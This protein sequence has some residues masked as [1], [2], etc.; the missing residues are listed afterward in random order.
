MPLLGL[1]LLVLLLF[2][3]A[4]FRGRIF[5]YRD[6]HLV[7]HAQVE[8]FVRMV[9]EGA[10]PVWDRYVS[11][12]QPHWANPETQVLYPFTWLQAV[13]PAGAFY[14]AFVVFHCLFTAFGQ[15]ALARSWGLER[16]PA[17][18]AAAAWTA[19]GPFL[20]LVSLWHHFTGA[21]WI[22][23]VFLA[24]DRALRAPSPRRLALAGLAA[25]AQ[26]LAG[27]ADMAAM[28]L[29]G[30]ALLAVDH[31]RRHGQA[32]RR[33]LQAGARWGAA[34]AVAAAVSAAQ[35]M[36][37][38][39]LARRSGRWGLPDAARVFWSLPLPLAAQAVVPAFLDGLPLRPEVRAVLHESREPFLSSVY[40]GAVCALLVAGAL[41]RGRHS[42]RA[43][44]IVL[45][46]GGLL[47]S[48]GRFAFAY[49]GLVTLVPPLRVFR[50]PV[51]AMVLVAFAWSLLAGLGLAAVR[52]LDGWRRRALLAVGAA[53]VLV[54]LGGALLLWLGAAEWGAALLDGTQTRRSPS[55]HLAPVAAGLF[56]AAAAAAGALV[57]AARARASV[58]W[59]WLVAP[60][61]AFDLARAHVGLNPTAPG[62]L[63]TF[64]PPVVAA[65]APPPHGRVFVYDYFR[66]DRGLRHLGHRNA[67]VMSTV[68]D[69]WP[70]PWAEALA[71][72]SYAYPSVLG[73][74]GLEGSFDTDR[75]GLF[76]GSLAQV[77]DLQAVA[78]WPDAQ[79]RL[80]ELGAVSHAVALHEA[81]FE[82]LRAAAVLPSL[83][84][85]PI[86]VFAVPAPLPRAHLVS[87]V[88]VAHG[89]ERLRLLLSPEFDPRREVI[90]EEG[91]P[92]P[93]APGFEGTTAIVELRSDR[94]RIDVVSSGAAHLVLADTHDPGWR[95]TVDGRPA[96]VLRANGAFT[97][98][99]VP[100]GRHRV[101]LAY[102]PRA[103][104]FGLTVSGL[105]LAVP[106]VMLARAGRKERA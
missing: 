24:F 27:S 105:A 92:A 39:E 61:A 78:E 11:F 71:L 25:T 75:L 1:G 40:L 95:G 89:G 94:S 102:R 6:I 67:Y 84:R 17:F 36:P 13:L 50:Y 35:W 10:W 64:R 79:R 85:E 90:L 9:A 53:L 12:G 19:S 28:T 74:W 30:T 83:F 49:G 98:V 43:F 59:A 63:L 48:L 44:L 8:S 46:A 51:K 91:S 93:P 52:H 22:P 45:A 62:T 97:A 20:S 2:P 77:S 26:V 3:A 42:A 33:A 34:W 68:R 87:G 31:A 7:W 60:L 18:V 21:S 14:T 96:P 76:A 16:A 101:E 82:A 47:V 100:A 55:W 37:T 66:W 80:L 81:G 72:R 58:R 86:R 104:T 69:E 56:A 99:A 15:Y 65:L 38:L 4:V 23:W 29:L 41:L 106:V 32:A 88:R 70:V 57:L 54:N 5:Y 73:A 103:V